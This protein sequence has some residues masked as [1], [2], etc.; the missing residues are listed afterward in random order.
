MRKQQQQP[1][2]EKKME[3]LMK[4][5]KRRRKEKFFY[6]SLSVS[7]IIWFAYMLFSCCRSSS[8]VNLNFKWK[9]SRKYNQLN[10]T[11]QIQDSLSPAK[12][13]QAQLYE[14][15]EN[16]EKKT[17]MSHA[18]ATPSNRGENYSIFC[19]SAAF[20]GGSIVLPT[21]V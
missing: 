20:V 13:S 15:C 1:N 3:F 14:T 5:I 7:T 17:G 6:I 2:C 4:K 16:R 9:N 21:T 11:I 12:P 19:T 18:M 8:A 10:H